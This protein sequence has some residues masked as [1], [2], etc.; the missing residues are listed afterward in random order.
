MVKVAGPLSLFSRALAWGAL[1]HN[2]L[3]LTES[4]RQAVPT[5]GGAP[6]D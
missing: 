1:V 5:A 6:T 3:L 2:V 4:R